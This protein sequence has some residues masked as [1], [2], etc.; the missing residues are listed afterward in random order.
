ML[1]VDGYCERMGPEFWAEPLNAWTNLAFAVAAVL[2]AQALTRL[3]GRAPPDLVALVVLLAA[4]A[5]GSFAFHTLATPAAALA[6]TLPI[7]GFALLYAAAFV[8]R[9]LDVPWR[10]AWLAAPAFAVTVVLAAG[11]ADLIGVA[12]P[13]IYLAALLGMVVF[14]ALLARRRDPATRTFALVAGLFAV[15]LTLRQ[16]DAAICDA[17]PIGTHFG[18]HL[19][20]ATVLG[21]LLLAAV[22]Q[23]GSQ[24]PE[25]VTAAR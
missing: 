10:W 13:G 3:P 25:P 7:A 14:A 11:V 16:L 24:R 9:F 6:D 15:S 20:N 1:R 23:A 12:A 19:L 2:G 21:A 4:I 17:L 18:W 8:R 5:V 22:R